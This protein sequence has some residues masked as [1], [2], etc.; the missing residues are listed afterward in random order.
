M[1]HKDRFHLEPFEDHL[2]FERGLSARTLDAYRRDLARFISFSVA[3]GVHMAEEVTLSHLREFVYD[4]RDDGLAASSIRRMQSALRTYFGFLTAD[5]V[6][7]EN[8]TEHLESPK[9]G[10]PLPAVLAVDEILALLE[11]PDETKPL[12]W[13][14][15]A[16]LEFMYAS[17]ARVSEVTQ[18]RIT[19]LALDQGACTIF[20]KGSKER[21]VPVGHPAC[22]AIE[23]YLREVRPSLERGEGAGVVFL[24]HRGR[25]LSRMGVFD[26][27][28]KA[29]ARAGI[30]KPVSPH[31][32]RH[33]F[34]THL[35]EGGADLVA[36][37]EMLGHADISTTQIYTHLDREYL[38]EVHREFHPRA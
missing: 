29:A 10:R 3:R 17:G 4:L 8:P 27:V 20:G 1:T 18:L 22:S 28:R 16:I 9:V 23:R 2:R 31:T 21:I 11:A 26:V 6:L 12:Y 13:R 36:V 37:Q 25:P 38:R 5:G 32:L 15:R 30:A 24:N 14:D 33:S 7:S 34:A 19:A 35:L